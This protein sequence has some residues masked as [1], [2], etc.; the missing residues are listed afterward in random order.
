MSKMNTKDL[1]QEL[2]TKG[3]TV[4]RQKLAMAT[5]ENHIV[6]MA[7]LDKKSFDEVWEALVPMMQSAQDTVKLQAGTTD[8]IIKLLGEGKISTND[9]LKMMDMILKKTEADELPRLLEKLEET[10][11]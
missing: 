5:G 10:E 4:I 2:L 6:N 9:A 3:I 11:I 8:E 1:R 7:Q